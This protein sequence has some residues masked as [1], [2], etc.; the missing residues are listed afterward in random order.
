LRKKLWFSVV[1]SWVMKN[2][3]NNIYVEFCRMI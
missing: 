1:S 2:Q 3:E